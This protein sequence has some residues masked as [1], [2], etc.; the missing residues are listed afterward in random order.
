[1][2]SVAVDER[3]DFRAAL[4]ATGR[5]SEIPHAADAYGWLV[6]DWELDVLHYWG[7]DVASRNIKGEVHAE[8]VLEGLAV[9]DV[10]IMPP[11]ARRTDQLERQMNMYG[12]TLRVWDSNLG[13]WRIMWSNPAGGHYEQQIGRKSGSDVVQLGS[14]PDGTITRWMFT[15][16]TANSFHWLGEA[17]QADG[18]SWM[19]E[20]E[21]RAQRVN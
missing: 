11:R 2:T 16:I 19:L 8:W 12:T 1:M 21:F 17:L 13:A 5:S 9:Q 10:W 7:K 3:V 20:G 15:E 18:K 14:R 4:A 6:G